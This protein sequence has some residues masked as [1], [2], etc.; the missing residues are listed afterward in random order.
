MHWIRKP[1]V[2]L[3][4][5]ILVGLGKEVIGQADSVNR[6]FSVSGK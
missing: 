6:N 2:L 3:V 1:S 4:A 5:L